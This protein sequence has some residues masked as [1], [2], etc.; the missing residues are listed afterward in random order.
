MQCGRRSGRT[1][2][3]RV[4]GV[5]LV[6]AFKPHDPYARRLLLEA[7]RLL[8]EE[9]RFRRVG[10]IAGGARDPD[11]GRLRDLEA[12]YQAALRRYKEGGEL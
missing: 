2:R 6:V 9:K 12:R 7:S 11:E 8:E 1:K 5:A 10:G 3:A 4:F